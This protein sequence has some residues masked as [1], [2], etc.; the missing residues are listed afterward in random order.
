MKQIIFIITILLIFIG[1]AQATTIDIY[2]PHNN[3]TTDIYYATNAGYN[4][5]TN[6]TISETNL[7]I[8]IIKDQI[9]YDDIITNPSKLMNIKIFSLFVFVVLFIVIIIGLIKILKRGI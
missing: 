3:T 6:N 4:T 8:L 2:Y 5:T 9:V 7:S 1:V